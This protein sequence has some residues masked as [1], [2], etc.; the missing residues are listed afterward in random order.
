[1]PKRN[2]KKL[3][4]DSDISK[5]K[6]KRQQKTQEKRDVNSTI[7]DAQERMYDLSKENKQ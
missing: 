5:E 7:S 6:L 3:R 2:W 1:M 4:T